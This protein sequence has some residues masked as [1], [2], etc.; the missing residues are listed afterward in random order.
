MQLTATVQDGAVQDECFFLWEIAPL[1]PKGSVNSRN[2]QTTLTPS[3]I[4]IRVCA[5]RV[6]AVL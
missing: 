5:S 4:L 1:S 6:G 2:L 3:K